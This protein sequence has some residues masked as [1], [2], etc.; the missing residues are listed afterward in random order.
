VTGGRIDRPDDR[1]SPAATGGPAVSTGVIESATDGVATP[2]ADGTAVTFTWTNPDPQEGDVYY[3]ARAE[4]PAE[5]QAVPQPEA[6]VSGI[7]AG[8][9]VCVNV[10][11]GRSGR[12]S[13]PLVICTVP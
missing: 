8:S 13:Q 11:I 1:P 5:R 4:T 12:T 9:R 7:V 2:S 6:T 3:W 10:E